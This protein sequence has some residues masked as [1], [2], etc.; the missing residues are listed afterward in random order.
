MSSQ[1]RRRARSRALGRCDDVGERW[2]RCNDRGLDVG[3][4]AECAIAQAQRDRSGVACAAFA[5]EA[6]AVASRRK[7]RHIERNAVFVAKPL[8]A[9]PDKPKKRKSPPA[10]ETKAQ[11][12]AKTKFAVEHPTKG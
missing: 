8:L 4:G 9:A 1:P 7:H 10:K 11:K 6:R 3:D 2:I 12:L 5:N